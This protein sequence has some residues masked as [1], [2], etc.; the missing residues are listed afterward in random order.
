LLLYYITDRTQFPGTEPE[1]RERLLDK[2][3]EAALC[4][5]DFVQLREKDLSGRITAQ[6]KALGTSANV[7]LNVAGTVHSPLL[8]PTG[9]SIAG[10]AVGTAVLG[11]GIGTSVGAKVGGWAE[12]L[13]GRKEEKR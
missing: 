7:P 8:Y 10:A 9:A 5:V 1:R 11:P 2:I 6:V 13:F 4:G 3:A 12:G